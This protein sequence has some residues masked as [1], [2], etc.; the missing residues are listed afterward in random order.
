MGTIFRF[1]E[2][3]VNKREDLLEDI[4]MLPV[5]IEIRLFSDAF[6]SE[7][8]FTKDQE[9][10]FDL[11][12]ENHQRNL[13]E[14]IENFGNLDI[15]EQFEE[16][17]N[18]LYLE[19]LGISTN[20]DAE[21]FFQKRK[22][23]R[24]E[25]KNAMNTSIQLITEGEYLRF[26][27]RSLRD[28]HSFTELGD[29]LAEFKDKNKAWQDM[30]ALFSSYKLLENVL[31]CVE[32]PSY[33]ELFN[34]N[35]DIDRTIAELQAKLKDFASAYVNMATFSYDSSNSCVVYK[36]KT[37]LSAMYMKWL[38]S[39]FNKD[40]YK[41]C[42][43]KNCNAFFKV[44]KSH[45]QTLCPKHIASRQRKRRNQKSREQEKHINYFEDEK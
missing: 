23:Y 11:L 9:P 12:L 18:D 43:H 35:T 30:S 13:P 24:I 7:V 45:P 36:C 26:F 21:E 20:Q 32:Y 34:E 31:G 38:I 1:W 2:E 22:N 5:R 17:T 16:F 39:D 40:T 15:E 41:Q 25:F 14:E 28:Y 44:N 37:L 42:G 29:K 19:L 33:I 4:S 6:A 8:A 27:L 10:L 3:T